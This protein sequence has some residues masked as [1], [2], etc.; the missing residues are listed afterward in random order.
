MVKGKRLEFQ[1]NSV[2]VE[3]FVRFC[4]GK[5]AKLM[6]SGEKPWK[7]GEKASRTGKSGA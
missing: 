3:R 1:R 2:G 6:N 5:N 7:T 4:G